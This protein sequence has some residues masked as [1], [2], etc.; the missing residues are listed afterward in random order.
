MNLNRALGTAKYANHAEDDG[1][2]ADGPRQRLSVNRPDCRQV[3]E[4]GDTVLTESPLSGSVAPT[5]DPHLTAA[6][7]GQSGDSALPRHRSPGRGRA[8]P[9]LRSNSDLP[10][11]SRIPRLIHAPFDP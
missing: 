5:G 7:A 3:L 1:Q 10:R 4:C 9:A 6:Q 2:P 11:G 8:R